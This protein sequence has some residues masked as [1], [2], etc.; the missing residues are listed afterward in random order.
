MLFL[1]KLYNLVGLDPFLA[2]ED[3]HGF[4]KPN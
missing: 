1:A 3:R 2:L 4:V